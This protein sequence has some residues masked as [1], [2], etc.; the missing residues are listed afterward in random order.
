MWLHWNT[1]S[2]YP[3][4][5]DVFILIHISFMSSSRNYL[6]KIQCSSFSTHLWCMHA[7]VMVLKI[8][9]LS[10]PGWWRAMQLIAWWKGQMMF[11][12]KVAPST[13][14]ALAP[15]LPVSPACV[16]I[17][18]YSRE[19]ALAGGGPRWSPEVLSNHDVLLIPT[20]LRQWVGSARASPEGLT[21][22]FI[23]NSAR[24]KVGLQCCSP[25]SSALQNG[26]MQR[27]AEQKSPFILSRL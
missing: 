27:W 10:P 8:R 1:S 23:C 19:P 17:A 13:R 11:V 26:P 9:C 5:T 4:R 15:T 21:L 20:P 22:T 3:S 25:A 18:P 6:P 7:T 24:G 16:Q 12:W 14:V 2:S